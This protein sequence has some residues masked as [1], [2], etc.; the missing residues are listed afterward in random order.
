MDL[1]EPYFSDSKVPIYLI[2]G[3]RW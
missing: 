3:T 2:V 1:Y